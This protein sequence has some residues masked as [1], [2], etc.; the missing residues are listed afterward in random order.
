MMNRYDGQNPASP[1]ALAASFLETLEEEHA[2]LLRMHDHFDR[3]ITA[4]RDH[5]HDVIEA[6]ALQ[7]SD[8]V[9]VLARLKQARDRQLRL[10]GRVLRLDGETVSI[11]DVVDALERVGDEGAIGTRILE[12]RERIR[13]QALRTQER[14]RDLE[15]ALEYSVHLGRELLEAIT[16]LEDSSGGRHYTS[17]GGTVESSPGKR[18]FLNRVG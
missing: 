10:L 12:V 15:F 2:S 11:R 9:N 7:T 16:G 13:G 17:T 8:E 5:D 14:C 3:Q 1:I 6:A 18:S 4:V